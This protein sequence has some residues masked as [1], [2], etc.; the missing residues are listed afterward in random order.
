[1]VNIL[2]REAI[3]QGAK[4]IT[5]AQA[6]EA[7][8]LTEERLLELGETE[9]IR[10]CVRKPE[11][12]RI[13]SVMPSELEPKVRE[14]NKFFDPT[15][16]PWYEDDEVEYLILSPSDCAE[17]GRQPLIQKTF[18]AGYRVSGASRALE[19]L[20]QHHAMKI[21]PWA[22]SGVRPLYATHDA[23][24]VTEVKE[25]YLELGAR[26]MRMVPTLERQIAHRSFRSIK[27]KREEVCLAVGELAHIQAY[28]VA[29]RGTVAYAAPLGQSKNEKAA[30]IRS[31]GSART[32]ARALIE[33]AVMVLADAASRAGVSFDRHRMP[34]KKEQFA[35]FF[36]AWA[37]ANGAHEFMN[38]S[39]ATVEG[40]V[41][42]KG[43][44]ADGEEVLLSWLGNAK[45]SG[46]YRDHLPDFVDDMDAYMKARE[47]K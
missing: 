14:P 41:K 28:C 37:K 21:L 6:V 11:G 24:L 25:H 10:L 30:S 17:I 38:K 22:T 9:R 29:P 39:P 47:K 3:G 46:F 1:M 16:S 15:E 23:T 42:L 31:E 13:F 7:T 19:V 36:H 33:K 2:N 45:A 27:L 4:I 20:P 12:F 35:A 43:K 34:G 5:L 44:G 40:Y 18:Q 32:K 8:G 26:G